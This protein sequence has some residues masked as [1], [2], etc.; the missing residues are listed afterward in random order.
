MD[1]D[2]IIK[3][4]GGVAGIT[5]IVV[6]VGRK[7][8]E[9]LFAQ[10]VESYKSNLERLATEHSIR[11]GRLHA[12]QAE[13][14]KQLYVRLTSLDVKL[15]STLR[16]FQHVNEG[17]LAAKVQAVG[18]AF[19]ELNDYFRPNRIFFDE[20]TCRVLDDLLQQAHGVFIDIT[21]L[22]VDVESV[23]YRYNRD[24]LGERHRFWESARTTY[25]EQIATLKQSL[26]AKFREL[27]GIN[28]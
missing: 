25:R 21:V 18:E 15:Q 6:F 23:E 4:L 5:A 20:S 22:P 10:R 12:E 13:V 28:A 14:I 11:F 27:L 9:T 3:F 26:E 17:P 7:F 24:L 16:A 1:W 8:I 19:N 2:A